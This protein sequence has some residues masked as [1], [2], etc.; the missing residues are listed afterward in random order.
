MMNTRAEDD[1]VDD[2]KEREKGGDPGRSDRS[3]PQRART[4]NQEPLE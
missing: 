2:T 4:E 1:E 3:A